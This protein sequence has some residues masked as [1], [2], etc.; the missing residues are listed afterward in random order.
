[1]VMMYSVVTKKKVNIP[2]KDIR[3]INKG[4]RR[5]MVGKYMANGKQY[6]AWQVVGKATK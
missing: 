4:G 2:E 5:F 6:E 1:M 3:Y